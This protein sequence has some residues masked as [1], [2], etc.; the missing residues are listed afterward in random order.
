MPAGTMICPNC[1]TDYRAHFSREQ[2]PYSEKDGKAEV[3]LSVGTVIKGRYHIVGLIGRGGFCY[4]YKATDSILGVEVAIKEYFPHGIASRRE[5]RMVTV[6]THQDELVF[7]KGKKRFL[8]EARGLAQFN[9]Y[10]N[11][12]SVYDFFEENGT[13]YIVMEFLRGMNLRDYMKQCGGIL[14]YEFVRNIAATLCDTLQTIHN[15]KFIHR[16][17]SPDNIFLCDN[18]YIKLIDF[19]ALNQQT[20]EVNET[21]TVILKQGYAPVEQYYRNGEQGPWTDIY[22]LGAT[23]YNFVTGRVP[24]ESVSRMEQDNLV[25]PHLLNPKVDKNFSIAIMKAMSVS[26]NDRY[27]SAEEFKNALFDTSVHSADYYDVYKNTGS[28]ESV[29]KNNTGWET[30]DIFESTN[31]GNS[32]V[33]SERRTNYSQNGY[34]SMPSGG[35][36]YGYSGEYG[37]GISVENRVTPTIAPTPP[38]GPT[39]SISSETR[40]LVILFSCIAGVL[41]IIGAAL[42]INL[43]KSGNNRTNTNRSGVTTAA[44]T[45]ST[46]VADKEVGTTAPDDTEA[47]VKGADVELDGSG[48]VI[49]IYVWDEDF[50][51][52]MQNCLPGYWAS[53]PDEPLDGGTYNGV[54]VKFYQTR[55]EY[56]DELDTAIFNQADADANDKI[57]IFLVEADYAKKYV[58]QQ[59]C[60]LD[61]NK[62]LG[63]TDDELSKQYDYTKQVMTDAEGNLRGLS[64]Q[65]CSAGMI[66][67]REIAKEVLGTDDPGE[68]Q[69]AVSDWD[70]WFETADKVKEKGYLM[71]GTV[72]T[73]MRIYYNNSA[74]NFVVDGKVS[75]PDDIKKWVDDS[76]RLID[77]KEATAED[78]WVGETVTGGFMQ[79]PGNVFCYF[80]PAW[81]F[82]FCLESFNPNP[83]SIFANGGWGFIVGPQS[84]YWGGT[85]ICAAA[86]SDNTEQVAQIMRDMT[87]NDDVMKDMLIIF[88]ECVNN[89]DVLADMAYSDEGSVAGLGGQNPWALLSE[90]AENVDASNLT[91]YDQGTVESF[92]TYMKDYFDGISDYDTAVAEWKKKVI[93]MYPELRE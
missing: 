35:N 22:A 20:S 2:R 13:A 84:F 37:R 11:V 49:N 10:P 43:V 7:D 36:G 81:Y 80:G 28:G 61:V 83:D 31:L 47:T 74:Q 78:P 51:W 70:K 77:A 29:K 57:D 3:H 38:T 59:D 66:Y 63:I 75:V 67:N 53:N 71:T 25:A 27:K 56:Q 16:D 88:N 79:N 46:E 85:W 44:S 1:G 93:E 8:K 60:V 23:L 76:K 30:V 55:F 48:E 21:V 26:K 92:Q 19:G 34:S 12:V 9:G 69:K 6:F 68:V 54:K 50:A 62:D 89:K 17:I 15:R 32:G 87:T 91:A 18:N 45:S 82:N 39:S 41:V 73:T 86:G 4:T 64:W 42:A 72:N 65:A 52:K 33:M 90:G 58:E 14:D 24:Q 5:N 40:K